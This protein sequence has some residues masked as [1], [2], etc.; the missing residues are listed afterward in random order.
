MGENKI[1]SLELIESKIYTVRGIQVMLD[2]DLAVF[3]QVKPIR[4]REQVKRNAKRFP[5]DFMFQL[6]E[7][8][9]DYMVSQ[10]AI[11]SR[12]HLGGSLPY[13]F[14]EQGVGALSAVL[15]SDR[16]IEV[17]IQIMRAFV[18]MRRF[19]ISNAGL[20]QR[21]DILELKQIETDNKLDQVLDVIES[22]EIQPRQG[23]FYN[24]QVFDAFSFACDLIR[25]AEKSVILIDNYV[26]DSVL[27]LLSKRTSGIPATIYTKTI[28]KQLA[29]DLI[30]HNEQYPPITIKTFKY[31]HDRFIIIDEKEIYHLG[32][33]LKDLGKKW[34]AFSRFDFGVVEMLKKL[35]LD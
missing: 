10:N 6:T 14:T 2:K 26:D 24:G 34:F 9:I 15:T 35:N 7:E 29:L 30:K 8:E 31:A 13:V 28:S 33:S 12:K 27:T 11:P 23:I 32:A 3:Y 16:A 19:L 21:I 18:A 4:L 1:E 17:G 22:K 25:G 20:F 5:S